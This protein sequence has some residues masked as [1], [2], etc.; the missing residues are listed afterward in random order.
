[1]AAPK[2]RLTPTKEELDDVRLAAQHLWSLDTN[3]FVPE[4][5]YSLNLQ[6]GK[7]I[8]QTDDVADKPLFNFV[9]KDKFFSIP[10]FKAFYA[11]LDNYISETG[12]A[13]VVTREELEENRT[14]INA[15]MET[16]PMK[17][18]HQYLVEK[19]LAPASLNDFKALLNRIWFTLFRREGN[20]DTSGFEHVFVGEER[21]GKVIG[22]H[23]W[24]QFFIEEI[25]GNV[26]YL[27]YLFPRKRGQRPDGHE[28]MLSIQFSWKGEL[29]SV[30]TIFMGVS[31]EFE[32]ALYTMIFLA[33]GEQTEIVLDGTHVSLRCHKIPSKKGNY[34]GSCFPELLD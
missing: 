22:F 9:K 31:P 26:N 33:A 7:K 1:M 28:H 19:K 3:R 8:Y 6:H 11:L 25:K 10:T 12:V 14:F 29:K 24:I 15:L 16:S 5:D 30:S 20:N 23:N 2:L 4:V 13:E 17:Y 18:L 27:G 32:I 34:L 21:D